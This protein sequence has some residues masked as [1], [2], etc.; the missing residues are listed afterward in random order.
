M[1][2]EAWITTAEYAYRFKTPGIP[3]YLRKEPT[4]LEK[5]DRE[6]RDLKKRVA[7]LEKRISDLNWT[8]YPDR[9]GQ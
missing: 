5:K 4:E 3:I 1:S 2:T 9:M 7:E 6:I 8:L